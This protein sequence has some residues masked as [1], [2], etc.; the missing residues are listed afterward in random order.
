MV[1]NYEK[2]LQIY[3]ICGNKFFLIY[4]FNISILIYILNIY[5][6]IYLNPWW[7]YTISDICIIELSI[8]LWRFYSKMTSYKVIWREDDDRSAL[9]RAVADDILSNAK[10]L[11]N[12]LWIRKYPTTFLGWKWKNFYWSLISMDYLLFLISSS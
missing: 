1:G 4:I 6:L 5:I 12:L 8:I 3:M 9:K 2:M 7:M 10:W 11:Y